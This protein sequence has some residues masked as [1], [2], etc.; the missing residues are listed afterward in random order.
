[1]PDQQHQKKTHDFYERIKKRRGGAKAPVSLMAKLLRTLH[2][3]L[4]YGNGVPA[5]STHGEKQTI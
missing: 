3:I 2:V 5:I 1:M 4:E